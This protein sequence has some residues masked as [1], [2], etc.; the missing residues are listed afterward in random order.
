M[1]YNILWFVL[2]VVL[3]TGFFFL[4]GFDYGVGTLLTLISDKE[5]DRSQIIRSIGPVWDGNEVWMI[6]AGGATF[7]AFPHVY[8]TMFS[9]FYIAL[10]LMLA[11]L[12]LRG[13]AFEFRHHRE[14]EAWQRGWSYALAFGS[15]VPAF[16][17]GVA[18]TNLIAGLP[19]G[20]DKVYHG[21]FFDL[22]T[23]Y[24]IVGGITFVLVFAFH[25]AA[26]LQLRLTSTYLIGRARTLGLKF[27]V[28]AAVFYV[29][30]MILTYVETDLYQS[31]LA[32]AAL[33]FSA[34]VFVLGIGA[35]Y[36]KAQKASFILGALAIVGTTVGFFAG[37]F[38]RLMV[39]S[40]NS[41]YSLTI[42]NASSTEYTLSIMT[43]AA[44]ILVPVVLCY[45]IW[46]YYIFRK[47]ISPND[48]GHQAY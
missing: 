25:G 30:C 18:V 44:A 11:A 22:L 12:I 1:D 26:F 9:T 42:Y 14:D 37:L 28:A 29:I 46:T 3:F 39:S 45:Q 21:G 43:I 2:I 31:G 47:R 23:P 16:L 36:A 4:E 40:L 48:S 41:G 6:T 7:A 32:T 13:V 33:F 10:F 34:V 27:G 5:S 24:T 35:L 20:A 8:A 17:W 15:I 19:I 38:P